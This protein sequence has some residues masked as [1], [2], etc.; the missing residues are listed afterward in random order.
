MPPAKA[1]DIASWAGVTVHWSVPAHSG[2][3]DF[4]LRGLEHTALFI[5]RIRVDPIYR[6]KESKGGVPAV[7]W[8]RRVL[9]LLMLGGTAGAFTLCA[10]SGSTPSPPSASASV[11]AE[12]DQSLPYWANR[13]H[14]DFG[15]QVSF[16]LENGIPR[17]I[18]HIAILTA[19][20]QVGFIVKD[21]EAPHFPVR[22]F[23][24]IGEGIFGN[25]VHPGGRLTG[26]GILFRFDGKNHGRFVPFFDMGGGCQNTT[27]AT[28][29]PEL[30]GTTQFSPRGGL[31]IQYFFHPQR[32][33]VFEYSY[34]H[35]SNASLMEPNHGW[36]G[37]MVTLGFRWLRRPQSASRKPPGA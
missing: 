12:P 2:L 16:A 31:G 5:T 4:Q 27:L 18:S 30:S 15:G 23:E 1:G 17:N 26:G 35:M 21:F 6:V 11:S 36:N 19:E 13:G 9:L 32:A 34:M 29:A 25:A 20:P 8:F 22:R 37:S 28:R 7:E 3:I 33:L 14:W 10:Q 24:I